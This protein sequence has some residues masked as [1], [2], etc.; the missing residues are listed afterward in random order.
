MVNIYAAQNIKIKRLL[1]RDGHS[2]IT[3]IEHITTLYG[4]ATLYP[5]A[6]EY[7]SLYSI[8][9]CYFIILKV[10]CKLISQSFCYFGLY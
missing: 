7:L 9:L 3:I 5:N 1:V 10:I 6:S 4:R 2:I 8:Y